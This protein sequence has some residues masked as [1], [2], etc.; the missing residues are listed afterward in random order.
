MCISFFLFQGNN[1]KII[2]CA[3]G[4]CPNNYGVSPGKGKF[5]DPSRDMERFSMWL[6]LINNVTLST[7]AP[8]E[9]R[10]RFMVCL[11]HFE[12][13]FYMRDGKVTALSNDAVP[14][15]FLTGI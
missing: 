9:V 14:T 2:Y 8:E 11:K 3:V 15:K 7:L 6:K 4:T 1:V 10:D 12:P 13:S 5:P